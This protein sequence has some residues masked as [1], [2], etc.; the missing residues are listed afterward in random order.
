[1]EFQKLNEKWSKDSSE[2]QK[3]SA[4]LKEQ[5]LIVTSFQAEMQEMSNKIGMLHKSIENDFKNS[6]TL[7]DSLQDREAK[8]RS[9]MDSIKNQLEHYE[10]ERDIFKKMCEHDKEVMQVCFFEKS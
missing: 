10:R 6:N 3:C 7:L 1:M 2:L 4:Y 8:H 9:Q 5:H